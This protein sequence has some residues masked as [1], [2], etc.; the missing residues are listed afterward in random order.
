MQPGLRLDEASSTVT[1]IGES[2]PGVAES[3]AAWRI[4]RMTT[5]GSVLKIDWADGNENYDNVWT[6]RASLTYL[7]QQC[8]GVGNG[9][10]RI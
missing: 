10:P 1:Y 8:E 7:P 4:K 3:A 2:A 9:F 5:S 6:D